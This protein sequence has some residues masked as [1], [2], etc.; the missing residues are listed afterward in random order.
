MHRDVKPGNVL[1]LDG[2]PVLIDFGIAHLDDDVRLTR[3][4]LVMGTPG[5]L[6]PEIVEGGEVSTSTDWW[7]WA[8]TLGFAASGRPPFGKG[9]MEAVLARVVRGDADLVGVDPG[10]VPLL[11]AALSP[12]PEDRPTDGEILAALDPYA[13]GGPVTDALRTVDRQ[14]AA[15]TQVFRSPPTAVLPVTRTAPA[16]VPRP[17]LPPAP[18]QVA[19]STTPPRP[20]ERSVPPAPRPDLNRAAL[21]PHGPGIPAVTGPA[22]YP[23]VPQPGTVQPGPAQ[24][25]GGLEPGPQPPSLPP[26]PVMAGDPRIGR[27]TRSGT[28]LAIGA[29]MV[30]VGAAMP[31][32]GL[33][34]AVAW[35]LLARTLD[36]AVTSLVLRRHNKGARPGD[37]WWAA[38]A[39]PVHALTGVLATAAAALIPL[40]VGLAGV[41]ATRLVESVYGLPTQRAD[42]AAA[43]AVG[44]ALVILTSWWGPGGA[45]LRR[46]SR[47]IARGLA[48]TGVAAQVTAGLALGAALGLVAWVLLGTQAP[49]W[50]PATTQPPFLDLL[51]NR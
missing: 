46:G 42:H 34:A 15:P 3:T 40:I 47:S 37:A 28:L 10:L 17:V 19:S 25:V 31:W 13:E 4:G 44:L 27:A 2:D 29:L 49:L 45:A 35:S 11:D 51:T 7:G 16:E 1:L 43:F 12:Y 22:A 5:Y 48:P 14:P 6:S 9:G 18:W 23:G 21:A 50:W 26:R 32:I 20:P 39:T 36:R 24:P 38:L 41:F 33:T 8:A 30:A